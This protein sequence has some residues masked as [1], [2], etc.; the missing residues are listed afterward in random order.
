MM[1][2]FGLGEFLVMFVVTILSIGLPVTII[3]LLVMLYKKAA[4]IE[5]LLKR[6]K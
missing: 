4:S 1:A 2:D 3:V 6:G 5:E